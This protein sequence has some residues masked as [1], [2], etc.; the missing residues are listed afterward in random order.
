MIDYENLRV[1]VVGGLKRYLKCPV[2]K[3]NQNA[4]PPKYP[5]LS[6]TITTLATAN[7]GTYG[8][9]TDGKA[10]K[11]VNCIWSITAQSD[12]N[13]ESVMLANKAHDYL[14]YVGSIYLKDRDVVVQSVGNVTNRDN[15][16]TVGYEYKN[17]FDCT[18]S[19][20][21]VVDIPDNGVIEKFTLEEDMFSNLGNRLDGV[22]RVA[23]GTKKTT[24]ED[25]SLIAELEKRLSGEE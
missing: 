10:R 5:Y 15:V 4:E 22:E 24:A 16:L 23:Y 19:M 8:E 11:P 2:I 20:V 6:Y 14:D 25:E 13:S 12:N 18:F 3:G 1:A 17:G 9:Y 7:R 21:D